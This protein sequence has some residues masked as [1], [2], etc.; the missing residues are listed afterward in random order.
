MM[1]NIL[2]VM[3]VIFACTIG[4]YINNVFY[5]KDDDEPSIAFDNSSVEDMNEQKNNDADLKQN[6]EIQTITFSS[7][8]RTYESEEE[9]Y[10]SAD[11]IVIG[12][13][14]S[15][16]KINEENS[17]VQGSM[18]N[19]DLG[20]YYSTA[21]FKISSTLKGICESESFDLLQP[22]AFTRDPF[23]NLVK[24]GI[25]GYVELTN[26]DYYLLYMKKVENLENTYSMLGIY[27]GK[28]NLGPLVINRIMNST[29]V[30]AN[31]YYEK[32]DGDTELVNKAQL[33]AINKYKEQ[34]D[35]F[36]KNINSK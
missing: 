27:Y 4:I 11:L 17:Y 20:D 21:P 36:A 13:I 28:I 33:E 10:D 25:R 3:I 32:Y 35:E 15:T 24:I 31:Y 8:H 1:K 23:D 7:S 6:D 2:I 14:S 29:D 18:A 12:K 19:R 34:I 30:Y 9:M 5:T 16:Y 22:V 26:N